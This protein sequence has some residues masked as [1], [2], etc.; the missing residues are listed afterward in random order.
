MPRNERVVLCSL[1]W[2]LQFY[3][4]NN[5]LHGWKSFLEQM[6][7]KRVA[8]EKWNPLGKEYPQPQ[9]PLK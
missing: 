1:S 4:E 2:F 5:F 9:K 3:Y 7:M 6:Q 8:E